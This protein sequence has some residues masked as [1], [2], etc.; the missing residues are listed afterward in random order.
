M[1]KPGTGKIQ[2][3]G[4]KPR[5]LSV[6]GELDRICFP[7]GIAFS[8]REMR[9]MVEGKGSIVRIAEQG[10]RVIGFAIGQLMP[11]CA[12]V[13]TLDVEP[14]ARGNGI[15]TALMNAL[16]EEFR[17]NRAT[18]SVLEVDVANTAAR[19]FYERLRYSYVDILHGYYNNRSD[20]Y[21]MS[22]DLTDDT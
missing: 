9:R 10:G 14:A 13:L 21:R 8:R 17:R 19:R 1:V 15:G 20:A 22:L 2:I 11:A 18:T 7:P 6:L 4:F 5:D 3:R 12:H 16:H